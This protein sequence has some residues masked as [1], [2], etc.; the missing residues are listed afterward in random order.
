MAVLGAANR[1]PDRFEYP[2]R[3]DITRDI[4]TQGVIF[5]QGI[6]VCLGIH[7]ARQEIQIVLGTLLRRLKSVRLQ[8]NQLHWRNNV[9][10]RG[11]TSLPVTFRAS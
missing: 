6:H 9:L 10:F 5:G 2:D 11:L 1:D 7:L 8:S 3:L 4:G